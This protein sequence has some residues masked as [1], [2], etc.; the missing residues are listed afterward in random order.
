MKAILTTIL[1]VFSLFNTSVIYASED[2]VGVISKNPFPSPMGNEIVYEA[3]YDG[4]TSQMHLWLS[5]IDGTNLRKI[6]TNSIADEEPTWSPDGQRIAF[7]ST[8]GAVTNIWTVW[9]D[10]THLIQL[11]FNALNNRQPTWSPD[12][13]KIAFV[14]D[15]GGSNDLWIMNPDG[16]TQVRVTKLPGQENH[17]SFSPTSD[18]I[19]FAETVSGSSSDSATLMIVSSDG[20]NLRSLTTGN[21]H[22]W[23]PSWGPEGILFASDRDASSEHW[24]I[25]TIKSNGSNLSKEGDLIALDPAWMPDGRILFT[26]EISGVSN[27]LAAVSILDPASGVK[28]AVS[29]VKGYHI[30]I[31]IRPGKFPNNINPKNKGRINVALLSSKNIDVT[32]MLDQATLTF[33]RTGDEQSFIRCEKIAKDV[34]SDGF[35]DLTCRF[36]INNTGFQVGDSV[37]ILRFLDINGVPYEGR[38]SIIIIDKDDVDDFSTDVN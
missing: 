11:T 34:N 38:D 27:V 1:V 36:K 21:F 10:G 28:H 30:S 22:D 23:N 9:T 20:S 8:I 25:W 19:V 35:L 12:G 18:E 7:A 2:N 15:R 14:S 37:G 6:N 13:S 17:P 3:D 29:N 4:M 5:N 31:D 32:K 24:K 33:G 16:S 26:D